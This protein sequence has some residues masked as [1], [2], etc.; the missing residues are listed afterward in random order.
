MIVPNIFSFIASTI[1]LYIFFR[2]SIPR[3]YDVSFL[4]EP[5][6]AIRD[7]DLFRLS[8]VVIVALLIGY[9]TSESFGVPVSFVA[10]SIAIIFLFISRK[11]ETVETKV[12]MK[13]APWAIVF[14]SIGMYVVVYLLINV[15]LKAV[16]DYFILIY[17]DHSLYVC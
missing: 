13:S 3:S 9:F 10:G 2:K 5:V 6:D 15:G 11:S 17:V 7:N 12:I 14:F 8:W 4:K 16:F 1:V